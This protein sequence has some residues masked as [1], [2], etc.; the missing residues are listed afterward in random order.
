VRLDECMRVFVVLELQLWPK[1]RVS[2]VDVWNKMP[3]NSDFRSIA[4]FKRWL[5][6]TDFTA[7]LK[8]F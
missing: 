8:R 1:V 6:N 5:L 7:F 4:A 3:D 2:V